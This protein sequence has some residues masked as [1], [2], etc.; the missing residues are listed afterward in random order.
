MDSAGPRRLTRA[1]IVSLVL[2][3]MTVAGLSYL[4][5][6]AD[7]GP[8]AVPPGAEAGDLVLEPCE[9][10]TED[11]GYEADCGTLV[12][13]ED[14]ADPQS[15]LI[16]L[17]VTRIRANSDRPGEPIFRLDGGPGMTNMGFP[18][19]SRFAE[20]HDVILVGY[21]GVDGSVRL[22]CPEV[23][24]ALSRSRDFLGD[25][26]LDAYHDGLRS[27]ADRLTREGVDL[28]NYGLVQQVD[29]METARQALGYDR[30]DLISVSAGTRTAM[31]YAWRYPGSI[32]RSVMVNVNPPGNLFW[33]GE[34]TDQQI[35]R[36]AEL[37][38]AD[39]TCSGRTNDLARSLRLTS[40]EIPDR[41]LF[42]PIKEGNVRVGSF[43]ALMEST[44]VPG[45]VSASG[46][47][48]AWISAA[49]GDGS[50]LWLLSLMG[51]LIYPRLFTWGQYAAAA[52]VDAA[53][54][55]EYFSSGGHEVGTNLGRA[56]SA[57]AWGGGRLV[58]A[59]PAGVE[60]TRYSQ[61]QVSEVE[62]LLVSGEL[63]AATPP[64]VATDQLLPH[65]PNG[66]HVVLDGFAHSPGFWKDQADAGTH[67]ITTFFDTGAV[68]DSLY[69][70]QSVD[71]SPETTLGA[72]GRQVVTVLTTLG[73]VTVVS[74]WWL[75]SR[76]SRRKRFGAMGQMAGRTLLPVVFGIGGWS[77][78][79][80][81]M[82][83]FGVPLPL[84]HALVV[85]LAVGIPIG[86]AVYLVWVQPTWSAPSSAQSFA[87]IGAA[88][89]GAGAGFTAT[90]S[91]V[92]IATAVIGAVAAA[93]LALIGLDIARARSEPHA[94]AFPVPVDTETEHVQV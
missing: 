58:E 56:A 77:I 35:R 92:A 47:F 8:I 51:D 42:L 6:A 89:V 64:Q 28:A 82:S 1:R 84:D 72:L 11:G 94:L 43:F 33:D 65:L 61:V 81:A 23:Q 52:R 14:R 30:I 18:E 60:E 26:A 31:I 2:I 44:A 90:G 34:S 38:A 46:A 66:H 78:A 20:R 15:R 50:G 88:L 91:P 13:L 36:Y 76:V 55:A 62:T 69:E 79:V 9:Y 85:T 86:S 5:L 39:T 27:C 4:R 73:L 93:N 37:C 68:D 53:A 25:E 63:D 41:W 70:P 67:L 3:A 24:A 83:A 17:P 71:F 49:D 48:D 45:P 59:W 21:R 74:L 40:S 16:A 32:H 7:T 57:F 87:V 19:A 22:D 29:D 12:V 54:A 75:T 10:P 80:L